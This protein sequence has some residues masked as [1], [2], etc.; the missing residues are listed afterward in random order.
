[1]FVFQ[2]VTYN[3]IPKEVSPNSKDMTDAADPTF[4]TFLITSE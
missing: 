2:V 4:V 1:M 3:N